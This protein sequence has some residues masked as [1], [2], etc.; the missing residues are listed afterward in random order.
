MTADPTTSAAHL[1]A[2]LTTTVDEILRDVHRMPAELIT[3]KPA[4][5]VWSVAEILCHI[6]EFVP[7]WTDEALRVAR[8]SA[9]EWGRTHADTRRLAA[10]AGASTRTLPD[11]ESSI[12]ANVADATAKIAELRDADLQVEAKSRNPRWDLKPA[13]FI[14]EELLVAHVEK[15][16]GQIRRNAAQFRDRL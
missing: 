15:H 1:A 8:R 2:R 14:V 12:R 11:L 16:L 7:Y 6:D 5:D 3:W 9:E 4:G 13:A 10:V